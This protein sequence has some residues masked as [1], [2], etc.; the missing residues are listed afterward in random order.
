MFLTEEENRKLTQVGPGTPG[1]ELLRRYWYP[2]AGL[3]QVTEESP[4]AFV[5]M[6]GE[7][8][9]LFRDKSG[10]VGLIADHCSHRGA[11]LLYGRVEERGIACAYHGWLYDTHGNCLETPAEPADSNFYLTVKHRAYPVEQLM[12]LY[13]AYLGPPPTPPI[14]RLDVAAYPV[15]H[16]LEMAYD[17]SWVQVVEN[18]VDSTHIY[19]LHQDTAARGGTGVR[20]TTRGNIDGLASL[21]YEELQFGIK[22]KIVPDQSYVEDDLLVFP[23][24]L[25]RVNQVQVHVPI[26]DTH[27]RTFK[28]YFLCE[29][30]GYD[31]KAAQ[32]P[33]DYYI[34]QPGEGKFGTGAYPDARYGIDR[35]TRQDVMAIETQGGISP[36]HNWRLATSDRGVALFEQVLL[37]EID[38]VQQGHDPKG[39][40]RDPNQVIDTNFE[41]FRETG[42]SATQQYSYEGLQVYTRTG[43][44]S[45][46]PL[47]PGGEGKGEGAG[48]SPEPS[49]RRP[50]PIGARA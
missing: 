14:R 43:A 31:A 36:R 42:G 37:R 38:R 49:G 12:G 19:I 39:V 46:S 33:V 35:L 4:T 40:V 48:A 50:G 2:I 32:D 34:L 27:T 7:D 18:H 20:S 6:L 41:F 29:R 22:R 9:V 8:L 17:A 25:R 30:N 16:I 11:S 15:E 21:D 1:G 24:M 5:R 44:P 26:D 23:N 10:G 47:P 13:W 3:H 28:L 45:P